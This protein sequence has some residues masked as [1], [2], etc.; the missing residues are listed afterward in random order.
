MIR[1]GTRQFGYGTEDN[2]SVWLLY[3][4]EHISLVVVCKRTRRSG[5]RMQENTAAFLCYAGQ[6][7]NVVTQCRIICRSAYVHVSVVMLWLL[8]HFCSVRIYMVAT[9]ENRS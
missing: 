1:K 4:R 8:L 3:A 5:Y 9:F 2:T 6:Y 7:I